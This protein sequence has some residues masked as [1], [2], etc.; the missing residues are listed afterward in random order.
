[1]HPS[2]SSGLPTLSPEEIRTDLP[3]R[4][5]KLKW[6]IVVDESLSTGL[7]VNAAV[8]MAAAVG[9]AIPGVLGPE[10]KDASGSVHVGLPWA[11]C[12]ILAS[13]AETIH[14]LRSK[15]AEKDGLL[16]VDMP[17]PAQ[18]SRVY[19][20]YLGTLAE[21]PADEVVYYA[22]SIIGPRNKVDKLVGKLP[23]LR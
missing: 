1:M 22:V 20:E 21:T 7:V 18:T 6:V 10:G 17:L 11:G 9:H 15:A 16:V 19:D 14:K 23:L 5:A 3:T 8:C 2:A 13:D 4:Q 12:S